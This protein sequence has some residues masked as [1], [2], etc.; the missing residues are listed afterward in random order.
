MSENAYTV[1]LEEEVLSW[2][3]DTFILSVSETPLLDLLGIG[4]GQ[5][6]LFPRK[7]FRF[8]E[9]KYSR[10][11][12]YNRLWMAVKARWQAARA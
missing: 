3:S 6:E 11:T 5:Q 8:V 7:N 12:W 2:E 9:A 1:E 4:R 10:D